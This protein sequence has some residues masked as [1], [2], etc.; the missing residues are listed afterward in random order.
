MKPSRRCPA[1]S[2]LAVATAPPARTSP[3]RTLSAL[4]A[5]AALAALAACNP[6]PAATVAGPAPQPTVSAA[7]QTARPPSTSPTPTPSPSP[8]PSP[9]ADARAYGQVAA[10]RDGIGKTYLGRE[11]ARVMS[12]RAA[13]WLERPE[14]EREEEPERMLE[15]LQ[16]RPGL[17]VADVGA[18]VGYHAARIARRVGPQ[19][20]VWAV[21]VQPEMLEKL[22]ERMRAQGIANVRPVL[23]DALDPGLPAG[24]IDLI[25]MVDVYHELENPREMLDRMVAA[26]KPGGRIAFVEYRAEDPGVP[27]LPL[28]RMTE[29]QVRREAEAAGLRWER[30][31]PGLPWQHLAV[32][33]KP[34]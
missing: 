10:S 24:A 31:W 3:A 27:I 17:A 22:R 25:L 11:I 4:L 30:T 26:L 18:G 21:E 14:R 1:P 32:F 15:Q 34:S 16:L 7:A 13:G 5:V 19:G 12:H 29:A 33:V 2:P 20:T 23:G 28:H 6:Q 9:A 8:S